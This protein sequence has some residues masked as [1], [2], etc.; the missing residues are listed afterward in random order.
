[1]C[2]TLGPCARG[3]YSGIDVVYK[4]THAHE[5]EYDLV[6][7]PGANLALSASPSAAPRRCMDEQ[8]QLLLDL[9]R[10]QLVH[11]APILY[12]DIGGTRRDVAGRFVL[13]GENTI[14]FEA[15]DYDRS[16]PL[17]LDPV[18]SYSSYLGGNNTDVAYAV[19]SD[20]SG[21]LYV[22]GDTLERQ[23]PDPG[24]LPERGIGGPYGFL[25][26]FNP[27]GTLVY[28]TY[29]GGTGFASGAP[30]Y[31]VAADATGN[32]V[33]RRQRHLVLLPGNDRCPRHHLRR[34]HRRRRL[35]HQVQPRRQRAG[36]Q[37]LPGCSAGDSAYGIALSADGA[38]SSPAT[39]SRRTSP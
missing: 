10:G 9:P 11:H 21:N 1:M 26:K 5:L 8:G 23:L 33:P 22:A 6:A 16:L 2:P 4:G 34:R 29:F 31:A 17:V 30:S 27:A 18:L 32:G 24:S 7:A 39:P 36:L 37:H 12:Q 13:T 3:V 38:R 19:T 14:G 15:D 35:P 28:S 25:S 20:L